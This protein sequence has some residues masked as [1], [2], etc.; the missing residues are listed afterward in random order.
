MPGSSRA[1]RLENGNPGVFFDF[2]AKGPLMAAEK[3]RELRRRRKRREERL[4]ARV[5]DSI[6]RARK[7]GTRPAR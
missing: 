1:V 6:A 2:T 3:K 5:K 7:G 4:K